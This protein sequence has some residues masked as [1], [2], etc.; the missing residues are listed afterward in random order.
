MGRYLYQGRFATRFPA[1]LP[2]ESEPC[3][4]LAADCT[5]AESGIPYKTV[6]RAAVKDFVRRGRHRLGFWKAF[7]MQ[8]P[9]PSPSSRRSWRDSRASGPA[10]GSRTAGR[11]FFALLG[12]ALIGYLGWL[13]WPHAAQQTY[14]AALPI[15]AQDKL[16]VP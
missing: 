13:L 5:S 8:P 15:F 3:G 7:P 1:R 12:V 9:R 11:W 14:I 4:G 2:A 10:P 6:A 16:T